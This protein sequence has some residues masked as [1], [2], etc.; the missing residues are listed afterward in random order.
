MEE[1]E[2]K[3]RFR[4]GADASGLASFVAEASAEEAYHIDLH[5]LA[6]KYALAFADLLDMF[7]FGV[8]NG[9]FVLEWEYHCPHCGGIAKES[10]TLHAAEH[11]DHCDLCRVNFTNKLDDNVEVFFSIHPNIRA[12]P[13]EVKAASRNRMMESIRENMKFDWRA[14]NSIQGIQII[15]NNLFRELMGEE[16]LK[17][18]QSL[19]ILHTTILFT[20]IKGSTEMYSRLGDA[21]AFRIVR[22][23]F[24]IL[25]DIIKKYEGVPVK[26]IGD[27][28]M[29][30]F[31]NEQ[32]AITAALEIQ[33]SIAEF[34]G[35]KSEHEKIVLK[36]GVHSG[37]TIVVTLNGRLDYFGTSVNTAAR[38]QAQALPGE[39]ALSETLFESA[40]VK[41][42]VGAYVSRAVKRTAALKG[43]GEPMALYHVDVHKD[44][45]P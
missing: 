28:V 18:D 35:N 39:V 5:A 42:L 7:I 29:G 45:R 8:K 23:H 43:L 41:R 20:D 12:I 21:A 25:F 17:P 30:V 16:V 31:I 32:K 34:S 22:D 40:A 38:I 44:G 36:I 15:Q 19:E 9:V 24:R 11:E 13:E 2:S 27:A 4:A 6:G 10:L 33:K 37:S 1:I 26:T 3:L 14:R